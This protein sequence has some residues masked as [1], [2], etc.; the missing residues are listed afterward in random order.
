MCIKND[1]KTGLNQA[2]DYEKGKIK[3]KTTTLT[4]IPVESF[5][6]IEIK[7]IRLETGLTQ[8]LFA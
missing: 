1:I 6:P 5:T 2:I 3:S 8:E 7:A 4:I